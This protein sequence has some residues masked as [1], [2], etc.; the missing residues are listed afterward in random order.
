MPQ[1][2]ASF[3]AERQYDRPSAQAL[4][5]RRYQYAEWHDDLLVRTTR[6][7]SRKSF[8]ARQTLR[9]VCTPSIVIITATQRLTGIVIGFGVADDT[10]IQTGFAALRR[11]L[12]QEGRAT[13][14]AASWSEAR[15]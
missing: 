2:A 14:K 3:I 8:G 5:Q 15:V 7:A 6:S 13:S 1:C 12:L 11:E 9:S 4:P 10:Q